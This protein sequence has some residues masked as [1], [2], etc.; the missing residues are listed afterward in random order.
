MSMREGPHRSDAQCQRTL[1]PATV[2]RHGVAASDASSAHTGL[3]RGSAVDAEHPLRC[4]DRT[5]RAMFE[6][7]LQLSEGVVLCH[8]LREG[9]RRH[10]AGT[11]VDGRGSQLRRAV[12]REGVYRV[13]GRRPQLVSAI[14]RGPCA[15]GDL[16]HPCPVVAVTAAIHHT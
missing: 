13:G 3:S 15:K 14:D 2:R 4:H 6:E 7:V 10:P 1:E 16:L 12:Q 11:V 5:V 9:T 8:D